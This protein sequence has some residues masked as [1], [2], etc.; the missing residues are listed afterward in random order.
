MHKLI[1]VFSAF[2]LVGLLFFELGSLVWAQQPGGRQVQN[3]VRN[4]N[5]RVD[6][7]RYGLDA[8]EGSIGPRDSDNLRRGITDLQ[9][10]IAAFDENLAR[11]R[12]NRSDVLEIVSAAVS[13]DVMLRRSTNRRAQTDW[14]GVRNLVNRLASNY[15]V[16]P[17]WSGRTS[18]YSRSQTNSGDYPD[19]GARLV[20]GGLT[21]TY[22]LDSARSENTAEIVSGVNAEA[23]QRQDLES[24]LEAP[25]QLALDIRGN[26]I[27]LASTKTSPV[28]FVADGRDRSEVIGG[29][30]MRIR[31]T[32]RGEELAISTIGGESDFTITF[33]PVDGGSGLKVTRRVTT[34]Y[35]NETILVESFYNKTEAVAGLGIDKSFPVSSSDDAGTFSSS[36]PNDEPG[37]AGRYPTIGTG[38]GDYIIP[39]GTM[40]VALLDNEVNTGVSQN[41]D[42]FKMIIQSPNEFRGAVLEGYLSGVG[43]SG[44]ISGRSNVTFNFDRITLRNGQ[45]YA[46]AGTLQS[47]KDQNGKDVKVDNEGTARGQSQTKETAKRGGLGA[48]LGAII[49]AIAG[50]SQGAAIGAIIGGGV[51]AGS[52]VVKGRDD[53]RLLKGSTVT[54]LS[55]S[56]V[57]RDQPVSEN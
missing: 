57:R 10:K 4:L 33:S 56:P 12:E 1:N 44:Q 22:R 38:G 9:D 35:L 43:R 24:K 8:Q 19:A 30:T 6:D 37:Y 51:G 23:S 42:R 18:S 47:V 41:N 2:A 49:G 39:N 40:L 5:S 16:S 31:A 27:V 54:I 34:S 26:Q 14:L 3:I 32:L 55:S 46:F 53:L 25:E 52:V 11:R 36:D 21:G 17:D 48:G 7:F 13:V 28:S 29:R 50:G 15:G 20:S 45:S